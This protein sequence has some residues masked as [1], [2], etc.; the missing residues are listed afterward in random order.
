MGIVRRAHLAQ[1]QLADHPRRTSAYW[2]RVMAPRLTPTELD[3]IHGLVE[4][5]NTPLETHAAFT[6]RRE[7]PLQ[8]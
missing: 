7:L 4:K 5:G 6:R 2:H 3:F 8:L 1:S